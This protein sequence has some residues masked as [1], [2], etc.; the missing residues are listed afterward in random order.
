MPDAWDEPA[1]ALDG[2]DVGAL[3]AAARRAVDRAG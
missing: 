1:P 2:R 3:A